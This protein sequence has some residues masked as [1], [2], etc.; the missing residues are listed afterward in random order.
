[1][2]FNLNKNKKLI[3]SRRSIFIELDKQQCKRATE[4]MKHRNFS[5]ALFFG[6]NV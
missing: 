2:K 4:A 1:M 3:E 5:V 6:G